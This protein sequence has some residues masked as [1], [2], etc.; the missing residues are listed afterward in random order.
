MT[1][2][3]LRIEYDGG[4]F[5]GWQRQ[6]DG[7]T[8]QGT[9]ERAAAKLNGSPVTIYGAGRTDAGV[10]A[11]GQAAHIDLRDEI[12]ARKIA[13]ALNAHLRPDPVAV[14]SAEA[15]P[16][17]FHARFDATKRYYRYE[18]LNRRADAT[19]D[20]GLVWRVPYALDHDAMQAAARHLIGQHDFSTFRDTQCQ[21]KTPVKTLDALDVSRSGDRVIVTCSA[22]SFLH[23][24]VRSMVGSLVEVGR[25]QQ[26]VDWVRDILAAADR[27]ACGPV[28]P[29][30]GLY[31][32]DVYYPSLDT[33]EPAR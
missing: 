20:H 19:L 21:S 16:E 28:A 32:E 30:D 26:P 18:I 12:P 5:W 15:V 24:Q 9:L 29:P 27:T 6:D 4:P 25:G 33:K 17:A 1:R 13:D 3:L 14:L 2:Y 23:K 22:L 8:V 7:P 10:H 11:R 31:L